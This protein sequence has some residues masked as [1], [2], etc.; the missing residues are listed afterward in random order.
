MP[1]LTHQSGQ[2]MFDHVGQRADDDQT[3]RIARGQGR[4]DRGEAGILAFGKGRLD[5]RA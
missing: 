5:A 4:H 2:L 1:E 3:G